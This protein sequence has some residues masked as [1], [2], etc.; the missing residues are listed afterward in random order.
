MKRSRFLDYRNPGRKAVAP[1]SW[2]CSGTELSWTAPVS[3][4]NPGAHPV[5]AKKKARAKEKKR[6]AESREV[7]QAGKDS[8]PASDPPSYVGGN[9]V[10]APVNRKTPRKTRAA[11]KTTRP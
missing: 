6:R 8:F 9:M 11:G 1:L 7:D 4:H 3:T 10:G 2:N 5:T